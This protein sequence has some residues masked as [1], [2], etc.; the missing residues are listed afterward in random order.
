MAS[1][2]QPQTLSVTEKAARHFRRLLDTEGREVGVVRFGV[3]DGGCA[4]MEYL[5]E[6]ADAPRDGDE[7]VEHHGITFVVDADSRPFVAGTVLDLSGDL[8]G[9]AVVFNNPNAVT[10]CGCGNS[11]A[12]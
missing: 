1:Q 4:G 6:L 8:N 7:I 11:F 12:V 3:K 10:T 9:E 5:L 2:V